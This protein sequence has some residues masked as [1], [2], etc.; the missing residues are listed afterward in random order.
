[1]KTRSR[2]SPMNCMPLVAAAGRR[3]L[4][5]LALMVPLSPA[6]AD[7]FAVTPGL[8]A[9]WY[10][11]ERAGEGLV[12]EILDQESALLYWFTYDEAGNQRWMLDVGEISGNEIV[13]P[14]LIV[15]RGGRFGPDFDPDE[16]ELEIVGSASLSFTDCDHGEFT[17]S[18]FG[19]SET[20]PMV[21][22]SQTMAAGCQVPHGVPGEP[23]QDYAGQSGSWYD[24]AHT[25]EGY[26]LQ[27]MSRDEALVVWFSYD[28]DG[29]QYWMTGTGSFED[30]KIEFPMLHATRGG[31]F[32][33]DFDPNEVELI[34]WGSLDMALECS[35]GEANYDSNLLEF[36]NGSFDLTRLTQPARPACPYQRPKLTDLFEISYE[37]LETVPYPSAA[38]QIIARDIAEDGTVIGAGRGLEI[39]WPD[40]EEWERLGGNMHSGADAFLANDASQAIITEKT[41]V[42][43]P[44]KVLR[45]RPEVGW[46]ELP[47]LVMRESHAEGVSINFE[48]VVGVGRIGEGLQ[49]TPFIWDAKQGQRALPIT[50]GMRRATPFAVSNNGRVVVGLMPVAMPG[51]VTAA[52][53]LRWVDEGE[54]EVLLDDQGAELGYVR[55]CSENCEVIIGYGQFQYDPDHPNQGQGFYI[56]QDGGFQYFGGMEDSVKETAL[57]PYR[58]GSTTADGTIVVGA[59]LRSPTGFDLAT[60]GLIWTQAT[61]LVSVSELLAELQASDSDWD[62]MAAIRITASGTKILL[63]GTRLSNGRFRAAILTLRPRN[64][65]GD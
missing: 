5:A 11:P 65:L 22:L 34:E 38:T 9:H 44:N 31:R 20:L 28:A 49:L 35:A 64:A 18:A 46:Q 14:E 59:Y 50:E 57:P 32:G 43:E 2:K 17:Y 40:S 61:G 15:T 10:S 26:T 3:L 23:I 16:V 63:Q 58:F 7:D 21:R 25:G 33:V 19:H 45:W 1:M 42:F 36:G 54:P 56:T 27:W 51:G 12:L 48:H 8:S 13:F 29:K 41:P 39:R 24:P 60:T 6:L 55:G 62:T 53:A 4:F 37:E 47:G 30:G 52:R